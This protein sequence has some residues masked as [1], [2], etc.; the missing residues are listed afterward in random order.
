MTLSIEKRIST[1]LFIDRE[2][3]LYVHKGQ[4]EEIDQT[5]EREAMEIGSDA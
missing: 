5:S 1:E 2:H 4:I 3:E